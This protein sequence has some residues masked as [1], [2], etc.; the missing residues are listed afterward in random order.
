MS[1]TPELGDSS[2]SYCWEWDY[3]R[4]FS[5]VNSSTTSISTNATAPG[6]AGPG[7]TLGLAYDA[8]GQ[9]IEDG[10]NGLAN[11]L[12]KSRLQSPQCDDEA[13]G[14]DDE[15]DGGDDDVAEDVDDITVSTLSTNATAP[16]LPGPGRILGL[17]YDAG[18]RILEKH[19]NRFATNLGLGP[20]ASFD[21]LLV[22]TSV[23]HRKETQIHRAVDM[24][25]D[26]KN[27]LVRECRYLLKHATSD[28]PSNQRRSLQH[29][30]TLSI[31]NTLL[32]AVFVSLG[33][34]ESIRATEHRLYKWHINE[35]D[36]LLAD[37]RRALFSLSEVE[38]NSVARGLDDRKCDI[39][40]ILNKVSSLFGFFDD[41]NFSFMALRHIRRFLSGPARNGSRARHL[42]DVW[43]RCME[44]VAE[45]ILTAPDY[46]DWVCVDKLVGE[47]LVDYNRYARRTNMYDRV[48]AVWIRIVDAVLS[49]PEHFPHTISCITRLSDIRFSLDM[50]N[51]MIPSLSACIYSRL[52]RVSFTEMKFFTLCGEICLV[53]MC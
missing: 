10:F 20:D 12:R 3:V 2:S 38:V 18:G 11:S 6:L 44:L 15:A 17:G 31:E 53:H 25:C 42:C 37:S 29:I 34:F 5:S 24:I 14:D 7:R 21:R 36:I 33:A 9:L 27:K 13:D 22:A 16:N 41:P 26:D 52:S 48:T 51:E 39:A 32:R 30:A 47:G 1:Q 43:I 4:R 46:L 35:R 40:V 49:S 8:I 50:S 45:L 19:L 23:R 28:N